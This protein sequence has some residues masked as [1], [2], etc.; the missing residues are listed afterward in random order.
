MKLVTYRS[1][2][3]VAAAGA[4]L[5]D[6]ATV[7]DAGALLDGSVARGTLSALD[8][9]RRPGALAAL[10]EVTGSI[11][12]TQRS[13]DAAVG[14]LPEI[15]LLAPV[16]RPGKIIAAGMNY[17]A[18]IAETG[19]EPPVGMPGFFSKLPSSVI[20]PF[21]AIRNPRHLGSQLDY[22]GELA[23]VIGADGILIEG[24]STRVAG[25]TVANDVSLRDLQTT[26]NQLTLGKG[27]DTFCPMGPAIHV[28]DEG[29]ALPDDLAIQTWVNDELRQDSTT[30]DMVFDI[31]EIVRIAAAHVTLEPG[32]VLL[33]GSP[34]GTGMGLRPQ[35]WLTEGDVV[36]I[37]IQGIGE[38]RNPV[39]P[40]TETATEVTP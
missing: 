14:R 7:L 26:R 37:R 12:G 4:L 13:S 39:A 22:E 40:W 32:D 29:A 33:T 31:A 23:V 21:E 2:G 24:T 38:I 35:R 9:L 8:V 16:P 6:E 3:A 27:I 5:D 30:A 15:Q 20:G 28:P 11:H 25:W 10:R 19:L 1:S 36:R 34:F 17:A 18:H